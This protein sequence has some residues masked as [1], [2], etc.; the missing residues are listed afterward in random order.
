MKAIVLALHLSLKEIILSTLFAIFSIKSFQDRTLITRLGDSIIISKQNKNLLNLTITFDIQ[1]FFFI[2]NQKILKIGSP[3]SS[4]QVRF[5]TLSLKPVDSDALGDT[6]ALIGVWGG[7]MLLFSILLSTLGRTPSLQ[8]YLIVNGA[9]L[10]AVIVAMVIE[11]KLTGTTKKAKEIVVF[12]KLLLYLTLGLALL[13][14][15]FELAHEMKRNYETKN[16]I[17][18]VSKLFSNIGHLEKLIRVTAYSL[19]GLSRY[20]IYILALLGFLSVAPNLLDV[21]EKG[22][23]G[24]IDVAVA[25]IGILLGKLP[26]LFMKIGSGVGTPTKGV[27]KVYIPL[28]FSLSMVFIGLAIYYLVQMLAGTESGWY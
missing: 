13:Q 1:N 2:F 12:R 19:G 18:F 24:A 4:L 11:G 28:F 8:S 20:T 16:H 22:P 27:F 14:S 26:S 9:M 7:F 15:T 17:G 10:A 5:E 23:D 25:V 6:L 21:Y 3:I